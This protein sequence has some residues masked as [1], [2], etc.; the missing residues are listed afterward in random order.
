MRACWSTPEP[1][2]FRF[3]LQR[4]WNL[5]RRQFSARQ[6][7]CR[8]RFRLRCRQPGGVAWNVSRR[9][10][11]GSILRQYLRR[12]VTFRRTLH[13]PG[14]IRQGQPGQVRNCHGIAAGLALHALADVGIGNAIALQAA[15]AVKLDR[16]WVSPIVRLLLLPR[17]GYAGPGQLRPGTRGARGSAR[18]CRSRRRS[19][20]SSRTRTA[21][22]ARTHRRCATRGFWLG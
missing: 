19:R 22:W 7:R 21:R 20:T 8:C 13:F 9:C 14:V 3:A 10:L 6:P 12:T 2:Q 4:G 16:H 11:P 17:S 1:G 18:S 15:W 5:P